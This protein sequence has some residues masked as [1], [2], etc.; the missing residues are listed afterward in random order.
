M[1][2]ITNNGPNSRT[3]L[4]VVVVG[5]QSA[6]KTSVLEMVLVLLFPRG[7]E[8]MMTRIHSPTTVT[9]SNGSE[10][11]AMVSLMSASDKFEQHTLLHYTVNYT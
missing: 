1:N 11:V 6:D 2:V 8:E 9:H 5:D 3:H 10:H 4:Q 7:G